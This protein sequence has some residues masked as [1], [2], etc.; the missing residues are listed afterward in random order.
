MP[1]RR[2]ILTSYDGGI[3]HIRISIDDSGVIVRYI[4]SH[5]KISA[6]TSSV[7]CPTLYA[8]LSRVMSIVIE[9]VVSSQPFLSMQTAFLCSFFALAYLKLSSL[10]LPHTRTSGKRRCSPLEDLYSK[11]SQLRI[12][13]PILNEFSLRPRECSHRP[14]DLVKSCEMP[15]IANSASYSGP[16]WSILNATKSAWPKSD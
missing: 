5:I 15:L 13:H 11:E 9:I 16:R 4:V 14:K 12:E 6:V 2:F 8:P 3:T 7:L 1:G 10:A